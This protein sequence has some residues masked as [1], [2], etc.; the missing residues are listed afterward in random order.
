MGGGQHYGRR[1]L[2]SSRHSHGGRPLSAR[3]RFRRTGIGNENTKPRWPRES[4]TKS[5]VHQGLS[6]VA[7]QLAPDH[8]CQTDRPDSSR[9][10]SNQA[11]SA[12]ETTLGRIAQGMDEADVATKVGVT[13]SEVQVI[14][15]THM[16]A[17]D[18]AKF[19]GSVPANSSDTRR[20]LGPL[21]PQMRQVPI[22]H[23]RRL[24]SA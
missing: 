5:S 24:R 23:R 12:R 22:Q 20:H 10:G 14:R 1:V 11:R 21:L 8:G 17:H 9:G 6:A 15:G 13:P 16:A 18:C 4:V 7:R 2:V 19:C 3:C